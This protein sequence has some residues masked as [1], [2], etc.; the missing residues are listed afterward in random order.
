MDSAPQAEV[1]AAET[2]SA[3]ALPALTPYQQLA[4]PFEVT[5]QD[6]RGMAYLKGGQVVTRLNQVLGFEGWDFQVLENG[7]IPESHEVWVHGRLTVRLP[8]GQ[9]LIREQIGSLLLNPKGVDNVKGAATD[10]LKK[11]ASLIGVGLYL[12]SPED[13]AR[14]IGA[15]ATSA[16]A[17]KRPAAR[18]GAPQPA[19][20]AAQQPARPAAQRPSP[21]RPGATAAPT[22]PRPAP[23]PEELQQ[24]T[25][26]AQTVY[27]QAG[28]MGYDQQRVLEICGLDPEKGHLHD[29]MWE[30]GLSAGQVLSGLQ[31]FQKTNERPV[32][33]GAERPALRRVQ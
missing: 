22:G 32:W 13:D 6:Q 26:A 30:R 18:R 33:G 16:P 20:P 21:A 4:R 10:A 17:E 14:E 15:E 12:A 3:Q 7:Y 9:T 24:V 31:R 28:K 25:A 11:C 2:A 19:R 1:P 23:T 29:L 27:M 8:G 5:H